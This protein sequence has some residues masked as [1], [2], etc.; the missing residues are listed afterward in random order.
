MRKKI[1]KVSHH[2]LLVVLETVAVLALLLA[3]AGSIAIWHLT[4]GNFDVGFA[5]D[6]IEE[7]LYDPTTGYSVELDDVIL[8]WPDLAGPLMLEIGGVRLLQKGRPVLDIDHVGLG[9][10]GR[11]LLLG[12]IQPARIV[13]TGPALH[14]V[15]KADNKI[16][17]GIE[18]LG[19][20]IE[21][22]V[23]ETYDV[24]DNP[25]M[26]IVR[27]LAEPRQKIDSRSPLDYL[28]T[29]E[30]RDARMVMEDHVLGMTWFLPDLD[31]LFARDDE[32]LVVTYDMKL[33]GGRT[34]AAN[35]R[36]DILYNRERDDFTAQARI[37]D[38]D[39]NIL[40]HYVDELSFLQKQDISF[41]GDI[42]AII[43]SDLQLEEAGVSLSA[44]PSILSVPDVYDKPLAV[45][46]MALDGA[47]D[48]K[49]GQVNIEKLLM[50]VDDVKVTLSSQA[51]WKEGELKAPVTLTV[52]DLPQ[53]KIVSLWPDALRGLPIE[54]WMT[55]R[56]SGGTIRNVTGRFDILAHQGEENWQIAANNIVAD[57]GIENM[58]V[59]YRAPLLPV[60]HAYATGHFSS[61]VLTIDIEK[62]QLSDLDISKAKVTID[63]IIGEGTGT[64]KIDVA[65]SGPLKSVF[66]YVG[67]E[68]IGMG[69]EKL[70]FNPKQV[71][72]RA[73]LDVNIS[74]PTVK[75]LKVKQVKVG[76][77]GTLSDVFLPDVVKDMDLTGGPLTLTVDGESAKLAGNAQLEGRDV[78]LT[79]QQYLESA[80]APY[81]SQI[82]AAIRADKGLREKLGIGLD[83]WLAGTVPVNVTYTELA[84]GRAAVDVT[85]DISP[86]I[87]MIKPFSYEKP[88]G[89][90]GT[91]TCKVALQNA[92]VQKI[93][94]LSIT[95]PDMRLTEGQFVF[96]R[97]G[98]LSQGKIPRITFGENDMG[99]EFEYMTTGALKVAI[100]GAFMDARPFLEGRKKDEPYAGPPLIASVNV[101]RMRTRTAR[102]VEQ[103]KI[104][105]N[106][107]AQGDIDQLEM[108]AVAGKGDVYFRLKP[109]ETGKMMVRLEADDA[110]S[111]LRAFD[112]YENV[113]GGKLVLY[114]EAPDIQRRKVL[115]GN[116]QISDFHVTKAPVLARLL[117]GIGPTGIPQLLSDEGIYFGRLE[118][119][120][121]W[122]IRPAGD[123]YLIKDGRT[124]GSALGLTFEGEVD[125]AAG[126]TAISGTIVPMAAANSL[127]GNIPLIGDI[128]AGGKDG[129]IFAA[130]YT[131]KGPSDNPTVSVNPL[132]A[133]AP[134]ILRKILF[135]G[136]NGS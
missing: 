22:E 65:L 131:I 25:V 125:K 17:L 113:E 16:I 60:K 79:W 12:Q 111:M 130:T 105:L 18:T 8:A 80:G 15:R 87:L 4:K 37:Q 81:E 108:D 68:P 70:G 48:R 20:E 72:G 61:D 132:A 126:K 63:H 69:E 116:V 84:G 42:R 43:N 47:Y 2:T 28:E 85:A 38:F 71:G 86:A 24:G 93:E 122:Y 34:D 96:D 104:Y 134:G 99:L 82:T 135:E 107:N 120:F 102:L 21:A 75:D 10:S 66:D 45:D 3:L 94:H 89:T 95:S 123:L 49:T 29:F 41:N 100:D 30:I 26:R 124:S 136:D 64:A 106:M 112:L 52:S 67:P 121:E 103:A 53:S 58:D 5:K 88:V 11:A 101:G 39:P 110:G 83:D 13:L 44:A 27:R 9:L 78:A 109:N 133:L 23:P 91:L 50:I 14:L 32:G 19:E 73:A 56:L 35:I 97:R 46:G 7:A 40:A 128:L 92:T 33:P 36:V 90:A 74:F 57:F 62:G 1:K 98:E 114:G 6:Y 76:V 31:T 51:T 117:S 59:D 77:K 115:V 127:V 54:S 118:S 129:A 119:G 55:E